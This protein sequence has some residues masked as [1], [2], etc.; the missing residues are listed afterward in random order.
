MA[1]AKFFKSNRTHVIELYCY[2]DQYPEQVDHELISG[3]DAGT[4]LTTLY[5]QDVRFVYAPDAEKFTLI[6][7]EAKKRASTQMIINLYE[8]DNVN[9][10]LSRV[11]PG[12]SILINAQGDT[13][14][15]LIAGY[16]AEELVDILLNDLELK[17]K[18]LKNLDL[19][20]CRMGRVVSYRNDLKKHLTNFQTLTTY[21]DLCTVSGGE[22]PCRMWIGE[23]DA[24][25]YFYTEAELDKKGSR[26]TEYT[27]NYE[28]SLKKIRQA[29]SNE[30]E[31]IDL[32]KD[33]KMVNPSC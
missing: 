18:P 25:D 26:I 32:F 21:T 10:L 6:L 13:D 20:A 16:D 12:D 27:D 7:H 29:N 15:Q 3:A 1:R 33:I 2:S 30:P 17:K 22:L 11:S 23:S 9:Y 24:G 4:V 14:A 28:S 5:G 8:P 19:D 31:E